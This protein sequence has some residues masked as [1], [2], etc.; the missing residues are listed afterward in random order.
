M[1]IRDSKGRFIPGHP[2]LLKRKFCRLC[3]REILPVNE[4]GF[5][6]RPDKV[7]CNSRCRAFFHK[8]R[9]NRPIVTPREVLMD[10]LLPKDLH[11]S[12]RK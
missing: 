8:K 6:T 11:R 3:G 5:K 12:R 10:K 9:K 2:S 1:E 7:F 4:Y